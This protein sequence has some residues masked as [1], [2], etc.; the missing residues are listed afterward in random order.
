MRAFAHRQVGDEASA[1]RVLL[2]IDQELQNLADS[3]QIY[4]PS[5]LE[6][7]ALNQVM[8]DDVT[9]ALESLE[10]AVSLGWQNYYA[11]VN[12]QRW[13]EVLRE[14]EFVSLLSWVKAGLDRQRSKVA[15]AD[16]KEDFR[17]DVERLFPNGSAASTGAAR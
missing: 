14:P 4:N 2:R 12:D 9:G 10:S 1:V 6:L 15:A 3:E 16:A 5:V 11:I 7:I 17:A 13:A 8:H